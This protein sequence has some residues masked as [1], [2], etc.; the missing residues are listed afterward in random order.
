MTQTQVFDKKDEK[1][2]FIYWMQPT[3][4]REMALSMD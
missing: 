1:L 4:T 3:G 2:I